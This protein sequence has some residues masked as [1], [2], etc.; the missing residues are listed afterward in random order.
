[1]KQGVYNEA[2]ISETEG[3]CDFCEEEIA[4]GEEHSRLFLGD[5]LMVIIHKACGWD[6]YQAFA[7]GWH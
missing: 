6:F 5:K 2:T 1:M 4:P 7:V 3:R